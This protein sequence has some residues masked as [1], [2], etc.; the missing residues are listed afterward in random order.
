MQFHQYYLECLSHASYLIGDET[1]GR[2]VVVDPQ[3]DVAEYLADAERGRAHDRAR[4]RDALPRRLPV[5]PPRAG[6]GHR[7]QDRVLLGRRGRVRRDG[8]RRRRAVL[9]RRRHA[10]VPAHAGT[11]A[12]VAQ[13]RGVRARRRRGT[14]RRAHRRHAVHRR[15]RTARSAGVDRLQPRRARRHALRLAARQAH[16]AARRDPGLPGPRRR[17]RVRQEPVDR[18]VVDDGRSEADQ[19]R[20]A[21]PRQGDLRRVRHRG[22]AARARLLR[23][24]RDPQPPGTRAARRDRRCRR[25]CRTT[26]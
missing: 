15:R 20:A 16:D 3:R 6:R 18:P 10:R 2:A 14:L 7:R 23:V 1:T 8:R 9:A 13:H 25:R 11:H 19:L 24:R 22:P 5:G 12:R 21:R 17:L 26:R 4:H